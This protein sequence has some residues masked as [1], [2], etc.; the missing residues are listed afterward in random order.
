[1]RDILVVDD[2]KFNL[3]VVKEA[4]SDEFNVIT[5]MSGDGALR[6]LKLKIPDLILL[7]INMPGMDGK[8]T[9]EKIKNNNKWKDIPIMFLTADSSAETEAECMRLG[10]DDFIQ[11][12]F[13]PMVMKSRIF[14]ILELKDLRSNLEDQLSQKTKQLE[15]VT[16]NSIMVIA[17]TIDAKDKYTSGHSVR[18]ADYSEAIAKKMGLSD[19]EISN[20]HYISL[21]HD[22]GKIGIPDSILNKATKLTDE[23]YEIIKKHTTIGGEILRDI[24]MIPFVEEGALYHHERYDGTGYPKGLKGE[25]IPIIARIL[26]IADSY[27]AITSD[28]IYR[29]KK[30]KEEAIKEISR[31]LGTQFDPIIGKIFIDMLREGYPLSSDKDNFS[32]TTLIE[33]NITYESSMLLS[34]IISEYTSD[35]KSSATTDPLTRLYN[36]SFMEDSISEMLIQET[37]GAMFIIDMD[38]FKHIND[39]YGHIVGDQT[40]KLLAGTLIN[41]IREND[42]AGRLGGDEFMLFI[43]DNTDKKSLSSIAENIIVSLAHELTNILPGNATSV[44]IGIAI[45]PDNGTNFIDLYKNADRALYFIKE[46]GK[47]SYHFFK[48][49]NSSNNSNNSIEA[50]LITLQKIL[51]GNM[52]MENG[53]YNVCYYDFQ[54]IY[55]FI[56]RY[57][58]RKSSVVQILLFTVRENSN[59]KTETETIE[60]AMNILE[61]TIVSSL[62]SSDVAT[63]YSNVQHIVVLMDSNLENGKRIAQ[64][65]I[66][67][68]N[69]SYYLKNITVSYDIK[70]IE[71]QRNNDDENT[72]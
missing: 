72:N 44:S 26:C 31:C 47:N 46:N 40:L 62:R 32:D 11:K 58:D 14:R 69:E 57:I 3:L 24:H 19:K 4:L 5:V 2:N 70:S 48:E 71:P 28:R 22:I 29:K 53:A 67:A 50:D 65:V 52:Q 23:E 17:N 55:N 7:D 64:R 66:N 42:L 12:P 20:I 45:T 6:Y 59:N 51:E 33:D 25:E 18:V 10:G 21:L 15:K 27:D 60:D 34:K 1:M 49:N 56:S 41:C 63:R 39:N 43:K 54:K 37:A 38:N 61:E 35:I 30:S 68:F 9:L 16:L 13:V 36:R 8:K